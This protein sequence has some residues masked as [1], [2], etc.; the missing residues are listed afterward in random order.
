MGTWQEVGIQPSKTHRFVFWKCNRA[1]QF[2]FWYEKE[3]LSKVLKC[4]FKNCSLGAF[5]GELE[6]SILEALAE[7]KLAYSIFNTIV[8][9]F[10]IQFPFFSLS[11]RLQ[12]T[13][14]KSKNKKVHYRIKNTQ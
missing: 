10:F 1:L 8:Y 3:R 5:L 14:T 13:Q 12:N 11:F 9:V 6:S 7:L 4:F 2:L